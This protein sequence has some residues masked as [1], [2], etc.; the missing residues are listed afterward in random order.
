[1]ILSDFVIKEVKNLKFYDSEDNEVKCFIKVGD[2]TI[3]DNNNAITKLEFSDRRTRD[4]YDG[5]ELKMD[6]TIYKV[7]GDLLVE[8]I[9]TKRVYNGK[10][11][12]SNVILD[13]EIGMLVILSLLKTKNENKYIIE[14][15]TQD[16][17]DYVSGESIFNDTIIE[18]LDKLVKEPKLET[19]EVLKELIQL[20]QNLS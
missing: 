19:V 15:D 16:Y 3:T 20:S 17:D 7:V 4:T 13:K 8:N 12:A 10:I 18:L 1:M 9:K 14:L 6:G 11:K 2:V 5:R